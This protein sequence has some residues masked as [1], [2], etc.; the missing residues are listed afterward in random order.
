[1]SSMTPLQ[2]GTIGS[3]DAA[4]AAD[5]G[6]KKHASDSALATCHALLLSAAGSDCCALC[7]LTPMNL[8]DVA[9]KTISFVGSVALLINNVTGGGMVVFN[10]LPQTFQQAGWVLPTLA[11]FG[12]AGLSTICGLMLI[13]AMTLVPKNNRFQKRMEYTNIAEYYFPNW[14]AWVTQF[15]YQASILAQNVSMIIQSV[16]VRPIHACLDKTAM[17]WNLLQR[18]RASTHWLCSLCVVTT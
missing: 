2:N 1:M 13:E 10:V 17:A 4:T 7:S 5:K 8:S 18:P 14:L 16:Q 12:V 3:T 15:A 9:K 6:Q 11:L